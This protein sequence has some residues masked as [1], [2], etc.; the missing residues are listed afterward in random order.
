MHGHNY[1]HMKLV[2]V[3]IVYYVKKKKK[4]ILPL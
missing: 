1:E 4:K 3:A 2:G